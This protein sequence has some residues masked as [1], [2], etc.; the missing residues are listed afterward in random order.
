M[1]R[2]AG[3][4]AAMLATALLAAG[5]GLPAPAAGGGLAVEYAQIVQPSLDAAKV[6]VTEN[7]EFAVSA[8][9]F[10]LQSGRLALTLPIG[11]R[12]TAAVFVGEGELQVAAP[13][14][15]ER[16]QMELFLHQPA[17]TV[18]FRQAV[19]RFGAVPEWLSGTG[20]QLRFRQLIGEDVFTPVLHERAK[21]IRDSGKPE[22]ARVLEAIQGGSADAGWFQADLKTDKYGWIHAVFDPLRR[23]P[24]RV[25][26]WTQS[27]KAGVEFFRDTWTQFA[28]GAPSPQA[29]GV[30]G[31]DGPNPLHITRYDIAV[32]VPKN[33]DLRAE[34]RMTLQPGPGLGRGLFLTFD[35]NL[36]VTQARL[37]D[38]R[39]IEWVQPRDPGRR[40]DPR[41]QGDWLYLE[42]PAAPQ[43]PV[44]IVL[45]YGGKYVIE[46]A[47]DGNYFC[48]SFGWYP[49]N[50]FG[51][52]FQRAAFTLAFTVPK[53]DTVVATGALLSNRTAQGERRE[54]FQSTIPLTVAGFA[55]GQYRLEK[56]AVEADGKNIEVKVFTNTQ[57]D[58]V[59]R[60]I[61]SQQY[62]P[63][64]TSGPG[65]MGPG[66]LGQQLPPGLANLNALALQ[67]LVL[68]EVSNA[69]RFFSFY[70]G[71][72][73]YPKLAVT[74]IP[75]DYGQGWPGL[76][77]LSSLSFLDGTQLHE[78]G[79]GEDALRQLSNTFR[80]H[81][82]SHQW[83]GH[84][85]SWNSA[86]DQWLSEGFANASAVLYEERRFGLEPALSTLREWRRS[87]LQKDVF[88]HV[89]D[90][91]GPLWLGS[92]LSSSVDPEGYP[93]VVYDKGG[94]VLYMLREM[95]LQ[96]FQKEPDAAF[97]AMMQ[98]FTHTYANRSASTA[99][100]EQV[101]NRHMTRDMDVD[102]SH[103]MDWFFRE[104]VYGTGVPEVIFQYQTQRAAG[105]KEWLT[106]H[107]AMTPG[108]KILL[109]VYVHYGKK[110]WIRGLIRCVQPEETIR[111]E[112]PAGITRVV[113]NQDE[114][115]LAVVKQ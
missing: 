44:R 17:V 103:S 110:R 63:P 24:V 109:P 8:L 58:D 55:L 56:Q 61:S 34:A 105:G 35:A 54:Q 69:V 60:S 81:E 6:A 99:D 101:V 77:Y 108:W 18:H 30:A 111:A 64:E 98:D 50:P 96:P 19:F 12:R 53:R 82:A 43:G 78:L 22:A 31:D 89:P 10:Q 95:M 21:A 52:P 114:D 90:N 86:N 88:G 13:N 49:S 97:I 42:L 106:M 65:S 1:R 94:Y 66:G 47:G 115:M 28:P 45:E 38:G 80:A 25:R 16:G 62:L 37:A 85:V 75:G 71:P 32:T 73:P 9:R 68:Q 33:L 100:F 67:K 26:R 102:G 79:F 83:W 70:F 87:L 48:R 14:T 41:Y 91:L 11:G 23:Q 113:A 93:V 107:V 15:I 74:N 51:P 92:R 39:P 84:V 7:V 59:F 3:V 20:G 36:R 2:A 40:T 57:P 27:A 112:V 5:Y 29:A 4:T 104:Y 46:R 76:L 72:Y